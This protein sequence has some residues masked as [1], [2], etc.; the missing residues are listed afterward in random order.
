MYRLLLDFGHGIDTPGKC[1][2]DGRLREYQYVRE[3][4]NNVKEYFQNMQIPVHVIVPEITDVPLK[5]RVRRVNELVKAYPEDDCRLISFH[6]NAAGNG[7]WMLARGWSV[8]VYHKASKESYRMAESIYEAARDLGAY[9]RTPA[10]HQHYWN[11]GFYILKNTHCPAILT[12]NFF[13]DNKDDVDLLLSPEGR[14]LV[15]NIHILG[16]SKYLNLPYAIC[17]SRP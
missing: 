10:L 2:P 1:S 12:E 11:A 5:E 14:E 3:I 9:I 8:F 4:G 17:T 15:S 13:Q 16:I 7:Q 6:V